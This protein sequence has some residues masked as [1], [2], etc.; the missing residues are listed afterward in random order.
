MWKVGTNIEQ[1]QSYEQQTT[2]VRRPADRLPS[3]PGAYSTISIYYAKCSHTVVKTIIV[4]RGVSFTHSEMMP[5][6]LP[7]PNLQ[8]VQAN[9]IPART[10]SRYENIST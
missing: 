8:Y 2:S 5:I 6:T 7:R 9:K 1:S 4:A 10:T 3:E